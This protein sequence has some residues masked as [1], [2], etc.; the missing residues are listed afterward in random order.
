MAKKIAKND[1]N[2]IRLRLQPK[3]W[4]FGQ[5]CSK[6]KATW[7]G[8]GGSRGGAKSGGL[9]RVMLSRR[10]EWPGTNGLIFRRVYDELKKNHIDKMLDEWPAL[11]RYWHATD[12]E[13]VLPAVKGEAPSKICFGYAETFEELK[14]KFFGL[15]FMDIFVDQGEQLSEQEHRNLKMSCRWPGVPDFRCK[16]G[17]FFN[18]GGIGLPYLKRVFGDKSFRDREVPDDYA[19]I[20]AYGW[21]NVEWVREA[22]KADKLTEKDFYGWKNEQRFDY[23]IARSQYGRDLNA[24]PEALRI[25]H[26]LGS[27]D[28]F[29]GQYFDIFDPDRHVVARSRLGIKPWHAKWL[30]MDWGFAHDS[31]I[32]WHSMEDGVVK[33]YREKVYSGI[34]PRAIAQEI[35]DICREEQEKPDSF[36]LS[37]DAFAKRTTEDSIAEQM[38]AVL[39][40]AG[41]ACPSPAD[42]DRVGGWMLMREMLLHGKWVIAEECTQLIA[43]IPLMSRDDRHP[44]KIE[45]CVKF[46]GSAKQGSI[47]DDA[48]DSARYGLKSRMGDAPVPHDV[49]LKA[50]LDRVE[51]VVKRDEG[52]NLN[53]GDV[54][55]N[56]HIAQLKFE[57]NFRK[58]NRPWRRPTR[59]AF[60]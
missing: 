8:F 59:R 46:D 48:A 7:L 19:F 18:P 21:D 36:Y 10:L 12:H 13:I 43:T 58:Q 55:T 45:D 56:Q 29:A 15:E 51:Q 17:I 50:A 57:H 22:L 35:V 52:E 41:I 11:R 1:P 2:A 24:L 28:V 6:S 60:A 20:Q 9:R 34:G 53:M 32:H 27:L 54:Y 42:N 33:T 47:G 3:Q 4:E 14:R 49:Q 25:G 31:V 37:P 38:R 16:Y 30:S 44:G 5:L 26:L 40:P 39:L 23:F